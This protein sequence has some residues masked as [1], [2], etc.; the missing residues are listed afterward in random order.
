[1]FIIKYHQRG[2]KPMYFG[3]DAKN[4]N[5]VSDKRYAVAFGEDTR[6]NFE[7]LESDITTLETIK[8][9]KE[10]E[11]KYANTWIKFNKIDC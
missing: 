6:K 9:S 11:R 10:A 3:G 2:Y 5:T 8:V 7:H 1:M 4:P